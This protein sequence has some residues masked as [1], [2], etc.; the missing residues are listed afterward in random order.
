VKTGFALLSRDAD[1]ISIA[2]QAAAA[3]NIELRLLDDYPAINAVEYLIADPRALVDQPGLK[4]DLLISSVLTDSFWRFAAG[5]APAQLADAGFQLGDCQGGEAWV[6]V[7]GRVEISLL[8]YPI[9]LQAE[10]T[11]GW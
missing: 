2:L 10:A 9:E 7:Q 1:L 11:A 6:R 4:P 3:V 8:A 5:Y